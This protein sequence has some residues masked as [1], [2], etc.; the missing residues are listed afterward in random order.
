MSEYRKGEC[1]ICGKI[2]D[3]K[4]LSNLYPFGSEGLKV[5]DFCS[6]NIT[7]HIR[8]L[9]E[10]STRVRFVIRKKETEK[11]GKWNEQNGEGYIRSIKK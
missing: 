7:M 8:K 9:K 6:I 3:I 11:G 10:L 4:Y 2:G 1:D 5:C